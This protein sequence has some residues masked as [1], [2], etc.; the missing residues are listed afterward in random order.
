MLE[1]LNGAINDIFLGGRFESRPLYLVLDNQ[2]R[3]QLAAALGK[4]PDDVEEYCCREVGNHL[5]PTGDPYSAF[6]SALWSWSLNGRKSRPPFTSLLF[7]LSHAAEQM[8]SDGEFSSGN[9][10]ERLSAL[11]GLPADKLS[12]HGKTTEQFWQAFNGWLANNDFLYG[13]PTARAVN[14]FKYVGIAMSQAIVREADLLRFHKLFEK[15]GFTDTDD[16]SES[17]IEQY[18]STWIRSSQPTKQLKEAWK[19]TELR[20]RICEAAVEELK[21]WQQDAAGGAREAQ[22][23]PRRLSLA[24]NFRHDIFGRSA[25]V[26]FGRENVSEPI[27]LNTSEGTAVELSNSTFGAFATLEPRSVI[28][29]GNSLLRGLELSVDGKP[30]FTWGGRAAIPLSRSDQGYWTE[31]SRVSLGIPQLVLVRG[32]GRVRR[33]IEDALAEVAVPGYTVS[34]SDKLKGLPVGWVLYENVVVKK[35][36]AQLSGFEAVLSPVGESASLRFTGGMKLGRGIWHLW[37]PPEV[38]LETAKSGVEILA[39]DGT[40][41]DGDPVCESRSGSTSTSLRLE[42]CIPDSGNVYLEGKAG[43]SVV[44]SASI[45]FRSANRPRPLDRQGRG[46]VAY[47]GILSTQV[48]GGNQ[49]C[50]VRGLVSP[51]LEPRTL[52]L[53]ILLRFRSLDQEVGR[54]KQEAETAPAGTSADIE[55]IRGLSVEE[56]MALPCAVRGLHRL[57]YAQIPKDAS[58]SDPVDVHCADCGITFVHRRTDKAVRVRRSR[59]QVPETRQRSD[60][61]AHKPVNVDLCLDGAC[62]LGAGTL[63]SFETFVAS[64]DVDTWRAGR[65]LRDL[66]WL[67]HLDVETTSSHR[68]RSWSISPPTISFVSDKKAVLT[69]YRS[70]SLVAKIEEVVVG[71]GGRLGREK[72]RE[73]AEIISV[74]G[75]KAADLRATLT[76]IDDPHGRV[77]EVVEEAASQLLAFIGKD[78]DL[79]TIFRPVTLGSGLPM[80][81]FDVEAN[82]WRNTDELIGAGA[83]R[84]SGAGTSYVFRSPSGKAHSGP[85]E[86]V[87]LAAAR[88][89]GLNLHS[90][91]ATSE[92]FLSRLG[93]EP[94]GLLGRALVSCSGEL[95][96]IEAGT[97]KFKNVGPAIAARV[98]EILYEGE[99]PK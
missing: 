44:A 63:A 23:G 36:L 95:P 69:G 77:I 74:I 57:V 94:P 73:H 58:K 49:D 79:S 42:G 34:T 21:E 27:P 53:D 30:A 52:N 15:Y 86:L 75:L 92:T 78:H 87:K 65:V 46:V 82:K 4:S 7:V 8:V 1:K 37:V 19:K 11:V 64:Q 54:E 48:N 51:R 39:W 71:V 91:D 41:P 2:G 38:S 97:S 18:I 84:I 32:D 26:Y 61:V 59:Q 12:L 89:A 76:D 9:Y 31:V 81:R 6:E 10:Y 80:Q 60:E 13:R 20:P 29:I 72:R 96:T 5:S 24:L 14:K 50:T 98:L 85:H 55:S 93:C 90:Y 43:K 83:Y 99:L 47:A 56:V 22:T 33:A 16:V 70:R 68:P 28:N 67:G 17:E 35:A 45:L 25:S 3:Q 66:A 88:E 62:F 40:G